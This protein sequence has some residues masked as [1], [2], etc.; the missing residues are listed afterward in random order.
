MTMLHELLLLASLGLDGHTTDWAKSVSG[1]SGVAH[2]VPPMRL[3][4]SP[5]AA[6]FVRVRTPT[7]PEIRRRY[8]AR[9]VPARANPTPPIKLIF[10][11]RTP[12]PMPGPTP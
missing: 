8:R 12:P 6:R 10:P 2:A 5:K 7:G 3:A 1:G 9:S 4:L 11:K